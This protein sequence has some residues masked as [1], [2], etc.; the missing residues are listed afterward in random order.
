MFPL[1]QA[2]K[3]TRIKVW[4][5]ELSK[6]SKE[7]FF[8]DSPT[9]LK[10]QSVIIFLNRRCTVGCAS[11]NAGAGP[12]YRGELSKEW[13]SAF[14]EKLKV[15]ELKFS[16]YIVW[17]GGEPFLS[18]DALQWGVSLAAAAGFHAE[19]LTSG[20]WFAAH[21]EW[22]ESVA[23]SGNVS[24]RISLDAEHQKIV[25]ISCV[26]DLT[27]RAL[28]LQLEVNYTL[29]EIPGQEGAVKRYVDEIKNNL[30]EFYLSS[31]VRSRWLH[32]IPHI[33]I[34]KFSS[35]SEFSGP[36]SLKPCKLVFRDLVI[37]DDGLV[38]P[39]CGLFNLPFY[40]RLAIGDPLKESWEVLTA[41]QQELPLFQAL[42]ENGPCHLCLNEIRNKFR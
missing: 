10:Y 42:K 41:R 7:R 32:Y 5:G 13:L 26:I 14:F 21:P 39:C 19:I 3:H 22:L 23:A 6:V 37:G 17:T 9:H 38:Y 25:S 20:N 15:E 35:R 24:L 27:R 12:D 1:K 36:V 11:C 28:E 16:G 8:S 29:R 4:V 30:P 2:K 33:T 31:K 18:I 40:Q 34:S